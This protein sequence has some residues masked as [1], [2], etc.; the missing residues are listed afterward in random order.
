[1]AQKEDVL[2]ALRRKVN[3]K[4]ILSFL[5]DNVIAKTISVGDKLK[6]STAETMRS[7]IF[8]KRLIR[9][10]HST[11]ILSNLSNQTAVK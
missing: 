7:W 6:A 9:N 4:L 8:F 2:R 5:L 11:V 1:M 10:Q 3:F